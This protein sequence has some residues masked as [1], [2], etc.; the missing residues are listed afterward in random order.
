MGECSTKN[1]L[2]RN[3]TQTFFIFFQCLLQNL[4]TSYVTFFGC[5][6]I[7][8]WIRLNWKRGKFKASALKKKTLFIIKLRVNVNLCPPHRLVPTWFENVPPSPR[9]KS[10][11][12]SGNLR[13]LTL[14]LDV[15]WRYDQKRIFLVK[16]L[17]CF[18]R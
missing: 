6:L 12:P 2:I 9:M 13:Q 14:T 15:S 4:C 11:K 1:A 7:R 17:F 5:P 8:Y 3:S 10:T 18:S 16:K